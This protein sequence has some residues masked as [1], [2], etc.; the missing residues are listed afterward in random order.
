MTSGIKDVIKRC[1]LFWSLSD[2]Q[3]EK[4]V[5]LAV[6]QSFHAGQRIITE[7][8]PSPNF[9][10][11]V[12][13]RVALEMEIRIGSRTRRQAAIDVVGENGFLGWSE[14][15]QLP[16]SMSAAAIEDTH[17]LAFE[18][19][20]VRRLCATDT[21]LGYK[22]MQELLRL[23]SRRFL[24][25][26][27][28]LAN[29][30]AVTSHDLR[31]PLAAAQSA[32]DV[33][34]GGFVGPISGRQRE[35]LMGGKQ[36][37]V[38]LLKMIDNILDISYIE[39]KGA[40]FERVNLYEVVTHS[41]GDVEGL[42]Q[43]KDIIVENQVSRDLP[44]VLGTPKRLRQVSTNL[45]GNAVKFTPPGGMVT[46]SSKQDP[47]NIQIDVAD[48]GIGIPA[49]ELPKIFGDFYRGKTAEAGAGL[50]LA[51]AK[52]IVEAHGGN[53]WA[54]SPDPET[55]QG[56]RFSFTLPVV[57]NIAPVQEVSMPDRPA[58]SGADILVVDDDPEMRPAMSLVL[59]SQGYSVRTAQDGEEGWMKIEEKEPD[60]LILD[61][62]M[63]RMDGFE[64]CKRLE[65]RR[66]SGRGKFPV[67]I[68]S[69]VFEENSRRRYELETET[70]LQVDDYVTKPISPP[71]LLQR[72]ENVLK[73]RKAQP[74]RPCLKG[75]RQWQS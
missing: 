53:I 14:F 15:L 26:R 32:L 37:I 24:Q 48:K 68:L 60:L 31:A 11:I 2:T 35:L 46:I 10:I 69:A 9:Y 66:S 30:L 63:P 5:H 75:D 61:L 19:S 23:A 41:L 4:L 65:E 62:L 13:G 43:R 64:V 16:A 50:G 7:G 47:D 42:A 12:K 39:I 72:V 25:T 38:D 6:Q 70:E 59:E 56:T 29:V 21:G 40:D 22:I 67:I 17:L 74:P 36:R 33:V 27:R 54:A 44:S 34:I 55:G 20:R 73:K 45:L 52:K 51:I 58:L 8:E 18:T 1:E 3:M 28:T 57:L 71:V 49:E